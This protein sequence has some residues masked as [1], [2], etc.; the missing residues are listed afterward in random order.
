MQVYT[1]K[2]CLLMTT[3]KPNLRQ[4]IGAGERH[5]PADNNHPF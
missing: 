4:E 5:D 3:L 1:G 2:L